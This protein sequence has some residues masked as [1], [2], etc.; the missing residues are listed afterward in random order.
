[1]L[2]DATADN[3]KLSELKPLVWKEIADVHES[4]TSLF[5]NRVTGFSLDPKAKARVSGG[6]RETGRVK[7]SEIFPVSE[8][9]TSE[10]KRTKYT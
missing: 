4:D 2:W 8:R 7:A 10:S 6:E 3:Y 1:M 9:H 5:S